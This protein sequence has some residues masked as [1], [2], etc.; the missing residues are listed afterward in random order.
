[1]HTAGH[2][3]RV[4]LNADLGEEVT[5]DAGLLARGH[6]RQ[7]RLRLPRRARRPPCGRS[8]PVP[9]GAGSW[10]APRCPTTTGRAS[11][12]SRRRAG[13]RAARAGRRAG[14]R[15]D[16]I[17][18]AEGAAR[19]RTSSR[20]ARS[21]TGSPDDAEQAAA[22]LA[23]SGTLPVLGHARLGPAVDWRRAPAGGVPARG[24][25]RPW[26]RADGRLA[27][28]RP[29][30][31]PGD[32][33]APGGVARGRAGRVGRLGVRAR[34]LARSGAHGAPYDA[35]S[36]PPGWRSLTLLVLHSLSLHLWRA[37]PAC[38]AGDDFCGDPVGPRVC[39]P[40]PLRR[41]VPTT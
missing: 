20:T 8:A 15:P 14:R 38:G 40:E 28:A 19:A 30:G 33:P 25:P 23:G 13:R 22:V 39:G 4:D 9:P 41:G 1:M 29:A 36:R 32:G 11:A 16:A 37:A 10:S 3:N 21:T 12:G 7:R 5:D 24:V 2:P 31:R 18:A 34:R 35:R 27:A 6:Q 26:L 17:A